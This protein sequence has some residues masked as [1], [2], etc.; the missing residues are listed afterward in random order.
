MV[1]RKTPIFPIIIFIANFLKVLLRFME[2]SLLA[3]KKYYYS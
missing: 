1:E 3:L 2:L